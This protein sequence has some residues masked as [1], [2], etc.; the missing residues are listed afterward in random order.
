MRGAPRL[1]PRPST[2]GRGGRELGTVSGLPCQRFK[3]D[4]LRVCR[5]VL[6]GSSAIRQPSPGT[7]DRSQPAYYTGALGRARCA[8]TGPVGHADGPGLRVLEVGALGAA[9]HPSCPERCVSGSPE[10]G[11]RALPPRPCVP[12][13]RNSCLW[14]SQALWVWDSTPASSTPRQ[15]LPQS[16][17]PHASQTSPSVPWGQGRPSENHWPR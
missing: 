13:G 15:E 10:G 14:P 4:L 1:T 16:R 12:C 11:G 2:W 9:C 8:L 7:G 17:L 6:V 5:V 3:S